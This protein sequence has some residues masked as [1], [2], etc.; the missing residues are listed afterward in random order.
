MQILCCSKK[1]AV[2]LEPLVGVRDSLVDFDLMKVVRVLVT[3]DKDGC[4]W[5]IKFWL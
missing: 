5:F 3:R 2:R 1:D 4:R